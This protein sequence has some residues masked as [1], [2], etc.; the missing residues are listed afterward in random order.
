MDYSIAEGV[1]VSY[2]SSNGINY[3]TTANGGNCTTGD[4]QFWYQWYPQYYPMYYEMPKSKIEQ[5]FKIVSKLME[6]KIIDKMS[7]KQFIDIV[8]SVAEIL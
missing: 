7:L 6:K 4:P 2:D 8:N 5:A 1:T 3:C